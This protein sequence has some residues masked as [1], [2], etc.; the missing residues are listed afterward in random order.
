MCQDDEGKTVL[1]LSDLVIS[2]SDGGEQRMIGAVI[3]SEGGGGIYEE[4]DGVTCEQGIIIAVA[5]TED[6]VK[7]FDIEDEDGKL[8]LNMSPDGEIVITPHQD[9]DGT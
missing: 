2:A 4:E 5:G 3:Y 6:F 7:A 1:N 8:V 9:G